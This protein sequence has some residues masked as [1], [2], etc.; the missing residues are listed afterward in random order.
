MTLFNTYAEAKAVMMHQFREGLKGSIFEVEGQWAYQ[1]M[2][3]QASFPKPARQR[4][5]GNWDPTA[6]K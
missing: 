2:K 5:S 6:I 3:F 1:P 4:I